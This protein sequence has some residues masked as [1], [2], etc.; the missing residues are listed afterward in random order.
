MSEVQC[1][2]SKNIVLASPEESRFIEVA[3]NGQLQRIGRK[4]KKE[5]KKT[6]LCDDAC[7]KGCGKKQDKKG[8]DVRLFKSLLC[9][10]KGS[11][12]HQIMYINQQCV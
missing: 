2:V 8:R 9:H 7:S 10:S 12:T 6:E 1:L 5:K 11:G 3:Q 4:R